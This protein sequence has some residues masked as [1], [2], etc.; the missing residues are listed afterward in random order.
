[1]QSDAGMSSSGGRCPA[2][3]RASWYRL[4]L[5]LHT[6]PSRCRSDVVRGRASGHQFPPRQLRLTS[7]FLRSKCCWQRQATLALPSGWRPSAVTL[8]TLAE[9]CGGVVDVYSTIRWADNARWMIVCRDGVQAT[10]NWL[11][12][13]FCSGCSVVTCFRRSSLK[14]CVGRAAKFWNREGLWRTPRRRVIFS[15]RCF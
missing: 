12:G 5:R 1:M 10:S 4:R 14:R 7:A 13:Q 9:P 2:G 6:R 3:T 11:N 8:K 15:K